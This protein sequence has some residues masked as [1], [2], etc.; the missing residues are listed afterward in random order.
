[1]NKIFPPEEEI[2]CVLRFSLSFFILLWTFRYFFSRCKFRSLS[3]QPFYCWFIHLSASQLPSADIHHVAVVTLCT[4][5]T[6]N[7]I[8]TEPHFRISA[9][10][11]QFS[12]WDETMMVTRSYDT[13][14]LTVPFDWVIGIEQLSYGVIKEM[15][16]LIGLKLEILWP[17]SGTF[18]IR[19]LGTILMARNSLF[20]KFSLNIQDV[21]LFLSNKKDKKRSLSWVAS[22]K[23][24]LL[25]WGKHL[26]IHLELWRTICR[27]LTKF[28][29]IWRF[30]KAPL[31]IGIGY[32]IFWNISH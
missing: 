20:C 28:W 8:T 31:I 23:F 24:L 4:H 16:W 32:E 6:S 3:W 9:P 13:R 1:M 26:G 2:D 11:I 17:I 19:L 27:T 10:T 22:I 29:I 30:V 7:A 5:C 21:V 18:G 12:V 14:I 15:G 25:M